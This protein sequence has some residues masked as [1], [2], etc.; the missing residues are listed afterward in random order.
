LITLCKYKS[1]KDISAKCPNGTR[2][3]VTIGTGIRPSEEKI[4]EVIK[5][6]TLALLKKPDY[7]NMKPDD[8]RWGKFIKKRNII[9]KNLH[10]W[11]LR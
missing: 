8:K 10:G 4:K 6:E 5:N 3:Y 2:Y 11:F 7:I 9:I 1:V